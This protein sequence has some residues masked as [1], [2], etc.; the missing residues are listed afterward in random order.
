[1]QITARLEGNDKLRR[2]LNKIDKVLPGLHMP[3]LRKA[4]KRAMKRAVPW[5]GGGSYDVPVTENQTNGRGYQRTGNLGAST[6]IEE[7]GH[8]VR[9][10]SNANGRSGGYSRRVI[11][12]ADGEGQAWMHKGRW[13][14]LRTAVDDELRV[15]L[16]EYDA[17]M[18]DIMRQE[19]IGL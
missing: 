13:V 6:Q 3:S 19:G 12:Y 8:S 10:V 11:G 1:M 5:R 9:I 14:L 7:E 17:D 18:S 2:G 16:V 15:F 4:M